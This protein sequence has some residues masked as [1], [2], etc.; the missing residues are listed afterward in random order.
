L[1]IYLINCFYPENHICNCLDQPNPVCYKGFFALFL[2]ALYGIKYAVNNHL[3]AYVDFGTKK[4]LFTLENNPEKNFWNYFFYQPFGL[5]KVQLK[6][7]EIIKTKLPDL[8]PFPAFPFPEITYTVDFR[9]QLN[10]ILVNHIRFKENVKT[11]LEKM[12]KVFSEYKVIGLHIRRT[13]HFK[14]YPTVPVAEYEKVLLKETGN[15]EKIFIAT[16]DQSVVEYF[17]KEYGDRI[18]SHNV[19]RSKD[20]QPVHKN[21]EIK[22]KFKLGFDALLDCYSLSLCRKVVI[23]NSC[24]S[25]AALVFNPQL[26]YYLF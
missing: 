18:I 17:R 11:G 10:E 13:D 14:E 9:K 23:T 4:Y 12:T 7:S 20:S 6:N 1:K 25:Y 8:Y 5:T 24:F 15:F 3:P 21:P 19:F 2:Q 22:N 16:D 26:E